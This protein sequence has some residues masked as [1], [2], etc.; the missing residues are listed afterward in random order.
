MYLRSLT[1]IISLIGFG[2]CQLK[3]EQSNAFPGPVTFTSP[4][5]NAE[6]SNAFGPFLFNEPSP[7][8]GRVLGLRPLFVEHLDASGAHE[9][10]TIVYPIFYYRTYG[11]SYEWS[12][13]KLINST[14]RITTLKNDRGGFS[15]TLDVWP[16]YFSES[17]SDS[18]TSSYALFPLYGKLQGHL[19]FEHAQF[20]AFPLYLSLEGRGSKT[21]YLPWPFLRYTRGDQNGFSVWPLFG[22]IQKPG[23]YKNTFVLWPFIYFNQKFLNLDTSKSTEASQEIGILPFYSSEKKQGYVNENYLWPLFGF[24]DRTSPLRYHETRYLWPFLVQGRG[25]ESY[26]NRF[27]PVY[28]HSVIK[29]LE[30]TWI[31]WPFYRQEKWTDKDSAHEKTRVLFFLVSKDEQSSQSHP[32]KAHAYKTTIWPLVSIWD[33]GAGRIQ[34]QLLSPFEG[35][36]A[37]NPQMRHAWTPLFSVIRFDQASQGETRLSFL[38]NAMT[39][40]KSAQAKKTEFDLGPLLKLVTTD[41]IKRIS[42]LGGLLGVNQDGF[43]HWNI[44]GL[45]FSPS[46]AIVA[47]AH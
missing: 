7:E 29:G 19:G 30:K 18:A 12:L 31:L 17:T 11:D 46:K 23:V 5:Q 20:L 14:G 35:I 22:T 39:W 9:E 10:T 33:N 24:S 3:A 4:G 37:D 38:W 15:D 28:T 26:V 6:S 13:F 41:G 27:G 34:T 36:F 2:L 40:S 8:G 21:R 43:R 32:E 47:Q 44:F 42:F 45:E 1:L 16:I 25:D